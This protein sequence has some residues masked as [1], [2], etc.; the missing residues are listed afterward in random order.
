[1]LLLALAATLCG[2]SF[3]YAP[4]FPSA[5]LTSFEAETF[6]YTYTVTIPGNSTFPFGLFRVYAEVPDAPVTSPWVLTGPFVNGADQG[7]TRTV[8]RWDFEGAGK[9]YANWQASVAQEIPAQT[10][11][12][13]QFLLVVPNSSPVEGWL[14]TSDG[15]G[16]TQ[17]VWDLVP[18]EAPV[19]EPASAMCILSGVA[20]IL[21]AVALRRRSR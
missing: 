17:Y 5:S 10:A 19:P 13:G 14:L 6:T 4:V 3:A 21:G 18:G 11:W 15:P 9:D 16:S 2:A 20:S 1:L 12:T 8:S 7:W